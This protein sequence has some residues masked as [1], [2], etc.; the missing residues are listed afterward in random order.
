MISVFPAFF[1]KINKKKYCPFHLDT[2]THAPVARVN[3]VAN[4]VDR[5]RRF[6]NVGRHDDL[7]RGALGRLK[8]LSG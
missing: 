7:A 8:D 6:G 4:A 5:E 3:H 1:V 2:H